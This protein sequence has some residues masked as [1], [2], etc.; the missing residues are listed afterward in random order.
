[1]I[2]RNIPE[3]DEVTVRRH[4]GTVTMCFSWGHYGWNVSGDSVKRKPIFKLNL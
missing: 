1:M 2:M 4:N 3:F